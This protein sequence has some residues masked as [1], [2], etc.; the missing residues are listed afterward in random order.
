MLI[1]LMNI[2]ELLF[3]WTWRFNIINTSIETTFG[4]NDKKSSSTYSTTN[5]TL[6]KCQYKCSI[7]FEN[8]STCTNSKW[9]FLSL[10]FLLGKF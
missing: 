9:A 5:T 1:E 7:S 8:P 3:R 10:L 4:F 2:S 6:E